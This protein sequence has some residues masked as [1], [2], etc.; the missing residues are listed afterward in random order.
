MMRNLF[1]RLG[2]RVLLTALLVC[3]LILSLKQ[4]ADVQ[5]RIRGQATGNAAHVDAALVLA[6][7]AAVTMVAFVRCAWAEEDLDEPGD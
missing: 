6:L 1:K 3:A 4:I 7:L 5:A 2:G